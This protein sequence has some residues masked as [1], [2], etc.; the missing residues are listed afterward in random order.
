[1]TPPCEA[2][3]T[4]CPACCSTRRSIVLRHARRHLVPGLAAGGVAEVG[5]PAVGPVGIA[6][7]EHLP[8]QAVALARVVLAQVAVLADPGSPSTGARMA[9]VSNARGI[10]LAYSTTSPSS[11]PVA[12]SRSRSAS[13]WARPRGDRPWHPLWPPTMRRSWATDSPCLTIDAGPVHD[14]HATGGPAWPHRVRQPRA[15]RRRYPGLRLHRRPPLPW[16]AAVPRLAC[17]DV[18]HRRR[19]RH[20]GW[21]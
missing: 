14:G 5:M 17:S 12:A 10:K 1:M 19:P 6:L 3:T 16:G 20:P 18:A 9:A 4:V 2:T 8:R 15:R 21:G 13:T 7:V 11:S